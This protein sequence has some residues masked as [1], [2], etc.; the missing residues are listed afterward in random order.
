MVLVVSCYIVCVCE[1]KHNI[2]VCLFACV[3][4]CACVRACVCVCTIFF[5]TFERYFFSIVLELTFPSTSP[6]GFHV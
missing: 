1:N 3:R 5:H 2:C 4:V 6:M